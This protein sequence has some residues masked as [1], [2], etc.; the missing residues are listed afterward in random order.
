M[1][2]DL[3]AEWTSRGLRGALQQAEAIRARHPA[4][5]KIGEIT[6]GEQVALKAATMAL[7]DRRR[8]RLRA[9]TQ[10]FVSSP[11]ALAR[12]RGAPTPSARDLAAWASRPAQ[13]VVRQIR[14]MTRVQTSHSEDRDRG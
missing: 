4:S 11:G 5:F 7:L 14:E 2:I 10:P 8:D 3:W 1:A 6:P 9:M 12:K 13:L